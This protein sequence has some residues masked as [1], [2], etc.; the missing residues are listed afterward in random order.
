VEEGLHASAETVQRLAALGGLRLS[1]ERAAALAPALAELL[2]VDAEIARL[3]IERLPAT[4][5]PWESEATS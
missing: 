2:A 5:L 4:G 1:L 3:G